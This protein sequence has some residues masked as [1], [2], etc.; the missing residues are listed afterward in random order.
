MN[1]LINGEFNLSNE[2][3]KEDFSLLTQAFDAAN[4]GIVL[5]D[6]RLPDNSIIYCNKAFE[7]MTG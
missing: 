5:T 2:S 1:N 7:Q 4:T 6:N 3:L